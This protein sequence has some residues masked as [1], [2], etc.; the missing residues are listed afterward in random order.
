MGEQRLKRVV[1]EA[2]RRMWGVDLSHSGVTA[3]KDTDQATRC[4]EERQNLKGG[5][6]GD[7]DGNTSKRASSFLDWKQ[8][9]LR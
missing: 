2:G 3:G 6:A 5:S 7:G 4:D 1:D 9:V 8:P